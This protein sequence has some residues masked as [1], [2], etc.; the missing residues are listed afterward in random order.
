MPEEEKSECDNVR[1]LYQPTYFKGVVL[2]FDIL[3]AGGVFC[4]AKGG[5]KYL[6]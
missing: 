5:V 1:E 3:Q 2:H 6:L 4:A